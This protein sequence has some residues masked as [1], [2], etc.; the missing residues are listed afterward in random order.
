MTKKSAGSATSTPAC[1]SRV[2]ILPI[3]YAVVPNANGAPLYRYANSGFNLE[4]GFAKLTRSSYTLRALRPGYVYVFMKGPKGEKL[5][6]HEYD[7]EGQYQELTYGGLEDY[8]KKDKYKKGTRMGWVW[9]DTCPDTAREVWVGYSPHLWTNAMTAKMATNPSVRQRHMRPLDMAEL[10][11]GVKSPSGQAHVLPA[12]ALVQWVEDFKPRNQRLPLE[13]SSHTSEDDPPISTFL[14]QANH[15]RFTQPRVPVVV[16]LNDAEGLCQDLGLSVSAYQHQIRDL[17]PAQRN[18]L[19]PGQDKA[20][21]DAGIIPDCFRLNVEVLSAKSQDYHHKNMVALLLEKTLESMYPGDQPSA[22]SLARLREEHQRKQVGN[23]RRL[24]ASELHYQVTT[25]ENIS[26]AGGRLGQRIDTAK[27]HAFLAERNQLEKQLRVRLD[28]VATACSDHDKWLATAEDKH[29]NDPNS[30]AAA[31]AS[32]DRDELI[33]ARGLETSLALMIHPMSQALP[34]TEDEDPR[35]KRLGTWMDKHDSP[36]YF[37]LAPFNPFKDKADVAGVLLGAAD[38]VIEGLSGRF[39]AAAGIT[40]L[41]S[42]AVTTVTLKRMQGK[43][44]W[45]ASRNLRQQVLTAASEANAEKA[46]GLLSARY[47]VTDTKLLTNP[48]SKEVEHFLKSG[49]KD[50]NEVKSLRVSGSRTVTIEAT[51]SKRIRP[52][53]SSLLTTSGG[54]A[55]NIAMLHFNIIALKSAYTSLLKDPSFEFAAGFASAIFGLIGAVVAAGV[56]AR[57][58]YKILVLRYTASAPGIAFG[59][60]TIRFVTGNLFS[61]LVGYPAILAG[62]AS[63]IGKVQRQ[64]KNGD[65]I[66]SA[67]TAGGGLLVML[68]SA[69]ILEGGMAIAGATAVVPVAG[70]AAAAVVLAGAAVLT[71]GVHLH[72]RAHARTHS[73]IELWAVRGVFGTRQNDGERRDGI[74]LDTHKKLPTYSGGVREEIKAWYASFYAP[75]LLAKADAE[76]L[77]LKGIDST[78]HSNLLAWSPPNWGSIVSNQVATAPTNVEFAV[79]LRGYIMGQSYWSATLSNPSCYIVTGGLVLHFKKEVTEIYKMALSVNYKPNQGLDESSDSN[80]LFEL[81]R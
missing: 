8:D 23:R 24:T 9:A 56:S 57:S 54:G 1:S 4:K 3:R 44:R 15:Y 61:R 39:P 6:I 7:G 75:V 19:Q 74:V 77:G 32:Y 42:E 27:F 35:F 68:G 48:F 47:G 55:L 43:T 63:D 76:S 36:L 16:A 28:I 20:Q 81:E 46:L 80:A 70:W 18:R 69:A 31:I 37:A 11:C 41:T 71:A 13:W 45:S 17:M 12:S 52:N 59:N 21:D 29:R 10:T 51:L 38:G 79:F 40:D 53:V 2:P 5:V 73:P 50:F 26:P 72:S 66:A 25:D 65:E 62:F 14:A 49:M 30:L 22:A 58:T 60:A 64:A 67:Y 34:G 78:W 33:S